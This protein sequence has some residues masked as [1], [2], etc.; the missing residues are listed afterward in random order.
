MGQI[1]F[2]KKYFSFSGRLNRLAFAIRLALGYTFL[3]LIWY[4]VNNNLEQIQSS[5][6]LSI[7]LL[8]VI[9]I[10][11]WFLYASKGQR[12]H[13]LGKSALWTLVIFVSAKEVY[14]YLAVVA[15]LLYKKGTVGENR[16]GQDPL[17]DE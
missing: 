17:Q 10:T 9:A 5:L 4:L 12:I 14:L 7:P 6:L 13:D 11:V 8:I 16:Y 1:N 15:F 3:I 2:F